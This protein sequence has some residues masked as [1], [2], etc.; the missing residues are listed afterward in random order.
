LTRCDFY[1]EEPAKLKN[2]A[3]LD[4]VCAT[5]GY[6]R[7]YA[8]RLLNQARKSGKSKKPGRKKYYHDPELLEVLSDLWVTTNL[9]CAKRLKYIIPIWLPF[10]DKFIVSEKVKQKLLK[11][12]PATIDRLMAKTRSKYQKRGLATTKPGSILKKRIPVKNKPVG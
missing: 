6:H 11:I 12:S 7:K 4:H 10:Y 5:C 3:I 1:I 2:R 8:I 9:P